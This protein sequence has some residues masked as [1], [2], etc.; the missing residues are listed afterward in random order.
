MQNSSSKFRLLNI[1]IDD[2]TMEEFLRRFT[3]G[4][5]VSNVLL[6]GSGDYNS[7]LK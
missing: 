5:V 1:D 4:I 3:G 6:H 7:L 2:L